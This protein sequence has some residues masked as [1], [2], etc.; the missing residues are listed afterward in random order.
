MN[1]IDQKFIDYHQ[2]EKVNMISSNEVHP[3]FTINF[4]DGREIRQILTVT[5]YD[6]IINTIKK[7][8]IESSLLVKRKRKIKKL[9]GHIME[10]KLKS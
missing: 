6:K 8:I 2:V 1:E 9:C 5:D 7:T 4:K 3:C 10:E